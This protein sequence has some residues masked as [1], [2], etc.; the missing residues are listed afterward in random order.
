MSL[1][2]ILQTF[3]PQEI[4]HLEPWQLD[5]LSPITLQLLLLQSVPI[6]NFIRN[7]NLYI[8][9]PSVTRVYMDLT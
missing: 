9:R 6:I 2:Q 3:D 7:L 8:F 4:T 5:N 1:S